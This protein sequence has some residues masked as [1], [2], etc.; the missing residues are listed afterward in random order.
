MLCA[1]QVQFI[2]AEGLQV[3]SRCRSMGCRPEFQELRSQRAH[4]GAASS[5]S[6]MPTVARMG[7]TDGEHK[8]TRENRRWR[9]L[10]SVPRTRLRGR[11]C[12]SPGGLTLASPARIVRADLLVVDELELLPLDAEGA[13]L[14][15]QVVSQAYEAQSVVFTTPPAIQEEILPREARPHVGR[16]S[17]IGLRTDTRTDHRQKRLLLNSCWQNAS[18]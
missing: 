4:R 13:W 1:V 16:C 8:V 6:C 12:V 14:L 2:L 18:R 11:T 9:R 3:S 15:F 5:P 17:G 10:A 7:G